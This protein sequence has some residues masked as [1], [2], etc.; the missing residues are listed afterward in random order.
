MT[1]PE[2]PP[3]V[4]F[5]RRKHSML[6]QRLNNWV[7]TAKRVV[8]RR[9]FRQEISAI[10]CALGIEPF[11][12]VLGAYPEIPFKPVRPYLVAGLRPAERAAAVIGHYAAAFRLMKTEA[13]V[14]S[15]IASK[16]LL[17]LQAAAGEITVDLTGQQGLYREAEWRLLVSWDGRAIV[18]MGLAIVDSHLL[19]LE[20]T[21]GPVLW[22]GAI[23]TVAAGAHGLEDARALTRNL[24]GLRPKSLL[25]LV[26]QCLAA[27]LKLSGVF[28]ASNRG[29][30]FATDPGL[31]RRISADYDGFWMESGGK[32]VQPTIFQLPQTKIRRS[33][34]EYKPNKRAQIRRR[35]QL[36]IE[37]EQNVH[38]ALLPLLHQH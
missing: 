29:H 38:E 20:G 36:E 2:N 35:H 27:G 9:I 7:R 26:A 21:M 17:T 28:A 37:I 22:I 30:V 24:A 33:L 1:P 32:R 4:E 13:F 6:R 23:K 11:C 34:G 14:Q 5:S 10:N 18:E 12:H 15:H 16:R 3:R 19:R 25:L 31:R 8:V